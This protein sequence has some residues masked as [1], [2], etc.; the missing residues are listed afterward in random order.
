MQ[1]IGEAFLSIE[2]LSNFALLLFVVVFAT[3]FT[4]RLF[5]DSK[6]IKTECVVLMYSLI[7]STV[8]TISNPE[9]NWQEPAITV[10][11][12]VLIIINAILLGYFA[13]SSYSKIIE[14]YKDKHPQNNNKKEN[15]ESSKENAENAKR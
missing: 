6:N 8:R 7:L 10:I 15:A 12:I 2:N 9:T 14:N 3:E 5:R 11:N 1:N 4:K 13:T